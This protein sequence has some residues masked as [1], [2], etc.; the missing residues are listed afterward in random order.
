MILVFQRVGWAVAK[1]ARLALAFMRARKGGHQESAAFV[2]ALRVNGLRDRANA[3][4]KALP[5]D[6]AKSPSVVLESA[7][8]QR[9]QHLYAETKATLEALLPTLGGKTKKAVQHRVRELKVILRCDV[10]VLA[11][12]KD[13]SITLFEQKS[14]SDTVIVTF[15]TVSSGLLSA[16]F[17]LPF[18][19][20][21]GFHQIHVAQR[22]F[23]FY[24]GL[25]NEE[26][27]DAVSEFCEGKKV[28]CYGSSLGGYAA[29]YYAG[30]I[31]A[32]VLASS[33]VNYLDNSIRRLRYIFVPN[34]HQKL[35]DLPRSPHA[36]TIYVDPLADERDMI[37]LRHNVSPAYPDAVIKELPGAGHEVFRALL[38]QGD[39]KRVFLEAVSEVG[40]P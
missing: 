39:L 4:L 8:L 34:R 6:V 29:L 20:E 17:G 18:I 7:E 3:Y 25:S 23:T 11:Q 5:D 30:G 14:G 31:Q 32:K 15:G 40:S 10:Q 37:F 22:E 36:P 9:G 35:S 21:N 26:F 2:R 24:Q 28:I 12:S 19:L 13:H 27:A 16:P 38:A 1:K 33:P